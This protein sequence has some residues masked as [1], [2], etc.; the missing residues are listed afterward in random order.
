MIGLIMAVDRHWGL[1][2]DGLIP[3]NIKEDY[4]FFQDVTRREYLWVRT[5]GKQ[6]HMGKGDW[7]IE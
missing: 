4:N 5:L 3:W 2:K 6:Y 7:S 1:S